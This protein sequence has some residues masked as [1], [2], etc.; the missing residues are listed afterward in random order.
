MRQERERFRQQLRSVNSGANTKSPR[1]CIPID[2]ELSQSKLLLEQYRG[3]ARVDAHIHLEGPLRGAPEVVEYLERH[4]VDIGFLISSPLKEA[5]RG[6]I[7]EDAPALLKWWAGGL[8]NTAFGHGVLDGL[9]GVIGNRMVVQEPDNKRVIVASKERPERLLAWVFAN[10]GA[11]IKKTL[12]EMSAF[13]DR[14]DFNIAGFKLHFW[15]YPTEIIDPNVMQIADLAQEKNLPILVDVGV[16][17]G[18]MRQF[19]E[20]TQ[21]HPTVPIIAAHLGS[22][23]SEVVDSASRFDNVFLDMSG[24]PVTGRNL[25][26]VF[27]KLAPDKVISIGADGK[28][29]LGKAFDGAANKII[30][31]SDSPA[32]L[33][34][35][36]ISQLKALHEAHL[37]P[38][39]EDLI[40]TSNII[41]IMPKV[42]K[43]LRARDSTQDPSA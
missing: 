1:G 11:E 34:G 18:N 8:G 26:R 20:F 41:S 7:K 10:P 13:A 27:N 2:K 19:D 39:E 29:E 38:R 40:L 15:V 37:T 21:S 42:A 32:G 23:L 33:G 4:G 16:N 25:R 36:I 3:R 28:V 17:R 9:R 5:K 43:L 6:L 30:W 24:Y 31:G 12:D 14:K 35:S 22:Y